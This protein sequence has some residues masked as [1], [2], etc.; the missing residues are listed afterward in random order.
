L[1][2]PKHSINDPT[3]NNHIVEPGHYNEDSLLNYL[4]YRVA[5]DG[6]LFAMEN[7]K[8]ELFNSGNFKAFSSSTLRN[9]LGF[10]NMLNDGFKGG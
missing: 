6:I 9:K 7:G 1:T 8:V 10:V 5:N 3:V 4:N 2:D